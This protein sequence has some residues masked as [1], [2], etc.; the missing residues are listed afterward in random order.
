VRWHQHTQLAYTRDVNGMPQLTL[1][2][3]GLSLITCTQR[4]PAEQVDDESGDESDRSPQELAEVASPS[5]AAITNR[6]L[7]ELAKR[8]VKGV[9]VLRGPVAIFADE[10]SAREAPRNAEGA[11]A[12]FETVFAGRVVEDRDDVVKVAADPAFKPYRSFFPHGELEGWVRKSSLSPVFE[13]PYAHENPDGTGYAFRPGAAI[14]TEQD[15]FAVVTERLRA[16]RIPG[17]ARGAMGASVEPR[18]W[19]PELASFGQALFC[20]GESV[21]KR[22]GTVS[23]NCALPEDTVL[24]IGDQSWNA[25]SLVSRCQEV[26]LVKNAEGV[27]FATIPVANGLVRARIVRGM[28]TQRCTEAPSKRPV[29]AKGRRTARRG[30]PLSLGKSAA[31]VGRLDRALPLEQVRQ[32]GKRTCGTIPE[33]AVE[34]CFDAR[35]VSGR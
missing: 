6:F 35:D 20:N 4:R 30:A 11:T 12:T 29:G 27:L 33:L 8:P 5:P 13:S 14:V 21:E 9:V 32:D 2:L 23:A 7:G 34:V 28:P 1:M 31:V 3:L 17:A 22:P 24:T 15:Q 25:G 18:A 10:A 26:D 16:F 19:E